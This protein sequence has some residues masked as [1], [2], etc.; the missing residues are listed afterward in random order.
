MKPEEDHSDTQECD[1]RRKS[2]EQGRRRFRIAGEVPARPN[3][4]QQFKHQNKEDCDRTKIRKKGTGIEIIVEPF[5]QRINEQQDKW[6]IGLDI[7]FLDM[8]IVYSGDP[9]DES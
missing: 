4:N 9:V 6:Q 3:H 2:S 7:L 5:L 1:T 8:L